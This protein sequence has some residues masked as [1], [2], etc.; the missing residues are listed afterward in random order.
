MNDK[1]RSFETRNS[2]IQVLKKTMLLKADRGFTFVE[3]IATIAIIL[4]LSASVGFSAMKYIEKART[5]AC[6]SQIDAYRLALQSYYLDSGQY[7]SEGQGLEALW[8]K[9]IIAPVPS[10]WDGPYTERR[11]QKD[12]WGNGYVYKNPGEKNLAF[13]IASY[14]ADGKTGGEGVNADIHSWE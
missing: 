10:H 13:T 7:P 8:E 1:T 12:P 2:K 9:P 6:R 14:G 4:I 11:I 5:A 3:T